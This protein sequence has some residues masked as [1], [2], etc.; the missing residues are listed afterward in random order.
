MW[1]KTVKP[2]WRLWHGNVW[3]EIE[4]AICDGF[5]LFLKEHSDPKRYAKLRAIES[6]YPMEHGLR[7]DIREV[8]EVRLFDVWK[9]GKAHRSPV[10]HYV[11]FLRTWG[12]GLFAVNAER[13]RDALLVLPKS[14]GLWHGREGWLYFTRE[15]QQDTMS[16]FNETMTPMGAMAM[17]D[18]PYGWLRKVEDGEDSER[19]WQASS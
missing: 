18:D 10:I 2:N 14:R 7:L 19:V 6:V 13:L 11:G 3:P 1:T 16:L 15:T 4:H 8:T 12:G 5:S 9:V 17:L